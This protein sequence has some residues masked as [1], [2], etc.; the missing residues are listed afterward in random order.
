[1]EQEKAYPL[2]LRVDKETFVA[3]S[4]AGTLDREALK[5]FSHYVMSNE[6]DY[7][8][9][10][11]HATDDIMF[12]EYQNPNRS[13]EI[14]TAFEISSEFVLFFTDEAYLHIQKSEAWW[15]ISSEHS[16]KENPC[17]R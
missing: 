16:F 1:M 15:R 10:E 8:L 5:H 9:L 2:V 17:F 13:L 3:E 4:L 12:L 6:H 11:N 14:E 7:H